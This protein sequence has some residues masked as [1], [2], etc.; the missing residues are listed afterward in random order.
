MRFP[1]GAC[2]DFLTYQISQDANYYP[3]WDYQIDATNAWRLTANDP[4][5][6]NIKLQWYDP[7]EEQQTTLDQA[8]STQ[9]LILG[10]HV[11][12]DNLKNI[13]RISCRRLTAK[14]RHL[15][16]FYALLWLKN[17]DVV[18]SDLRPNTTLQ[19]QVQ[20]H[21]LTYRMQHTTGSQKI[22]ADQN[23]YNYPTLDVGELFFNTTN[24]L[25]ETWRVSFDMQQPLSLT[26]IQE[27]H[28]TNQAL[29]ADNLTI[30][31]WNSPEEVIAALVTYIQSQQ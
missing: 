12:Y 4:A 26:S 22:T 9:H 10:T 5:V 16:F 7:T 30:S 31:N 14:T 15:L 20:A 28:Q 24:D 6:P 19:Q 13:P 25:L 27:H 2:G 18:L 11:S 29:V 23:K 17:V 8:F 21:W 1:G 3:T